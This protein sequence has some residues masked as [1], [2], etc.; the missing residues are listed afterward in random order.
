MSTQVDGESAWT[1]DA[2][3][4]WVR[5]RQPVMMRNGWYLALAG[6]VLNRG[7]STNDLDLVAMPRRKTS[8]MQF[9]ELL[10]V[11]FA[12]DVPGGKLFIGHTAEIRQIEVVAVFPRGGT[13]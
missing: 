7:R 5:E 1:L 10:G 6:G 9:I 12:E 8:N 3:L 11:K 2:A 13:T 4:E